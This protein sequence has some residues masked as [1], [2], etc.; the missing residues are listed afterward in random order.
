MPWSVEHAAEKNSPEQAGGGRRGRV[1]S[2]EARDEH[3]CAVVACGIVFEVGREAA[4]AP[5]PCEQQ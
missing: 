2:V 1:S 3:C 4:P 5:P